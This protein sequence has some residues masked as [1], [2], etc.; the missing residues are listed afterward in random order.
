MK[1]RIVF[2]VLV[3]IQLL[4]VSCDR[5]REPVRITIS[6]NNR[7]LNVEV[8]RTRQERQTG[9]MYRESLGWNEGML[10]IFNNDAI[11]T[12]WMKD[13][14]IPLS[15]AFLDKNGEVTDIFDM[16]PYSVDPVRSS[17]KAR[18]AV[19]VNRGYFKECGLLIGDVIDL[20]VVEK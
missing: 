7:P 19:E 2:F 17:R 13:T 14:T 11:R 6:I 20:S 1:K 4:S 3:A 12:F 8:A 16:E 5:S 10:F 18:Y 15:I 9:L